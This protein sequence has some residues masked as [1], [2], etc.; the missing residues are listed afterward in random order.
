MQYLYLWLDLFTLLGPL[1][2]SF[3]KKVAFY[4]NWKPL[5]WG[6]IAMM[7]VF[8]PW[9]IL[10]TIEGIW[11]FNDAY[12]CGIRIFHLPLEEW[13]FFIVVP[14]A[15]IF[16][17]ECVKAYFSDVLKK[18]GNW[19]LLILG[20]FIL[21]VGVLNFD[22]TYTFVNFV[23]AAIII[24][25]AL[26][27]YRGKSLGYFVM[28]FLIALVPFLLVNGVLTGTGIEDQI[29]WYNSNDILNIRILTIPIEDTM[30]CLFMLLLTFLVYERVK[31]E[32]D[33][34]F[35]AN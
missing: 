27:I 26:W 19:F 28:S 32:K 4:K 31:K 1:A 3:D 2:L 8:I 29:V 24:F 20:I 22:K 10:F 34:K 12:L 17:Y 21:I 11:S 33:L 18:T 25:I 13:L 9:D 5:F 14:Y 35:V 30:Y 23:G 6:T 7:A 16:I 15:C